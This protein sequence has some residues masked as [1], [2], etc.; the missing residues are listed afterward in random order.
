MLPSRWRKIPI[1][2]VPTLALVGDPDQLF[3]RLLCRTAVDSC[4]S[5]HHTCTQISHFSCNHEGCRG[6]KQ[7][8]IAIVVVLAEQ[9]GLQ[10][11]CVVGGITTPDTIERSCWQPGI[12]RRD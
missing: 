10:P 11:L 6:T 2:G 12:R 7:D 8:Y 5:H 9:Q 3:E 1:A 4:C